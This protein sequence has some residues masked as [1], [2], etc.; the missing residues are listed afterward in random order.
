MMEVTRYHRHGKPTAQTSPKSQSKDKECNL[1]QE[2]ER[3]QA[4]LYSVV[5]SIRQC[6]NQVGSGNNNKKE[7]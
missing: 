6:F 1:R 2:N 3:G 4:G 5:L 7:S